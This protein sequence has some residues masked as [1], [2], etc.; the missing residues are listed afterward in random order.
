MKILLVTESWASGDGPFENLYSFYRDILTGAGHDVA[1][2]DNKVMHLP[3]G[4]QTVWNCPRLFRALGWVRWNDLIVNAMLRRRTA[5]WR[6]EL[7]LVIKGENIRWRT[8]RWIKNNS[9]ALLFNWD[10][11]NP[12]WPSNTSMDLL[13]SMP[14][15]DCFGSLARHFIPVLSALGCPRAEYVPMFF[16]PERFKLERE[17]TA[18]DQRRYH[19]DLL[20]IGRHTPERA[21]MLRPLADRDLALYG[22]DWERMLAPDDSLRRCLRGGFLN[23]PEYAKALRCCS[24]AINV[25]VTQCKGANNLRTFEATG[26]GAFLLTEYSREQAEILFRDGEEIACFRSAEE[27]ASLATHYLEA[28]DQRARVAYA[29]KRRCHAEHLLQHRLAVLLDIGQELM[30][31]GRR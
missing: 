31:G 25:L 23:G 21:D 19:C 3:I 4:G 7:I 8:L 5:H 18:D 17:L 29:G 28:A 9:N 6:P 12:F 1:V 15:Y 16:V 10:M 27:L 24:I 2:V 22:P 11:D 30:A 20:F 26:C 14:Y 13:R